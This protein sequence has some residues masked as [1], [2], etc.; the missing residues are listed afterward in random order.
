VAT[1]TADRLRDVLAYDCARR[2][3][4]YMAHNFV[5]PGSAGP[6]ARPSRNNQRQIMI[7]KRRHEAS[8]LAWLYETG[9]WP[10]SRLSHRDGQNAH[11]AFVNLV[12]YRGNI[13]M[14]TS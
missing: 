10:K 12:P 4:F 8:W 9:E 11:N 14:S 3:N 7:D 1:L 13:I 5:P 6:S 2:A